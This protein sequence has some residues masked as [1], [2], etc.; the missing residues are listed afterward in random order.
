MRFNVVLCIS[1]VLSV[2]ITPMTGSADVPTSMNVQ[3]QLTDN[4]G[5]PVPPGNKTFV[6]KIFDSESNGDKIWP[7]DADDGE[8]QTLPIDDNR[9]WNAHVGAVIPLTETVFQDTSR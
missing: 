7:P 3:G 9:L 8:E 6:F 1:V 5:V 2:I 4:S